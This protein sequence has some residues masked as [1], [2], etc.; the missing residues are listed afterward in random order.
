MTAVLTIPFLSRRRNLRRNP[1]LGER[2]R[3]SA[4]VP[5]TAQSETPALRFDPPDP[6]IISDAIPAF[7]IGRDKCGFWVAREAKGR[8]GGL[9]LLK[10]SALAFAHAQGG[11]AGCATIFPHQRFELD[12]EN[13]GNP[14]AVPLAPFVRLATG[15]RERIDRLLRIPPLRAEDQG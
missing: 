8:I 3:E 1:S 12:L 2:T 9:F 13:E 5:R 6:G 11:Q 10:S 4:H 14:L 7:Y 15:C